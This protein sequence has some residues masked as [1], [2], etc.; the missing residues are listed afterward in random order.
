METATT[1]T[2]ARATNSMMGVDLEAQM[3]AAFPRHLDAAHHLT[4]D[5]C[6]GGSVGMEERV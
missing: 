1:T 5:A 3:D 2:M 4:T 6:I